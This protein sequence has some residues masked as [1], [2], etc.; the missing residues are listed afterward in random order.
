MSS[1]HNPDKIKHNL[2]QPDGNNRKI[3]DTEVSIL[4]EHLRSPR[5]HSL[6][7][8]KRSQHVGGPQLTLSRNSIKPKLLSEE[9][10]VVPENDQTHQFSIIITT[11]TLENR[12]L[13]RRKSTRHLI[14]Q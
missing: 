9:T 2:L 6:H 8:L 13:H 11:K 3:P 10:M 5:T 1:Q 12:R 4:R 7:T 14:R